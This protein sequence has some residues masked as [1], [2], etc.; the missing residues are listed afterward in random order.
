MFERT[1]HSFE[2]NMGEYQKT[3]KLYKYIERIDT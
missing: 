3:K 1:F 2:M